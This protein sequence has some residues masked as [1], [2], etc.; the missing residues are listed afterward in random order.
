MKKFN[1]GKAE[2]DL[3]DSGCHDSE[4]IYG[5]RSE[6]GISEFMKENG[7]N[8]DKYYEEDKSGNSNSSSN[9]DGCYLTTACVEAKG[10]ADDCMELETL[11]D[12]RDT[13][14]KNMPGGKSEVAQYYK[15]AP[16][17]VSR[18]NTLPNA[19]EI[20][21]DVFSELIIPAVGFIKAQENEK[22]FSLYKGYTLALSKK[23]I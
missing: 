14:I 12:F 17:I 13:Y 8:P 3:Y 22:A 21:K 20:W 16:V 23:Y 6:K 15:I 4:E 5:Y 2:A 7:L 18:I 10:L 11:R 19:K 1:Y 9:S